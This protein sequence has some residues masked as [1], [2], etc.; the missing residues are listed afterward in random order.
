M[1][2][3]EDETYH[4]FGPYTREKGQVLFS[5]NGNDKWESKVFVQ[6]SGLGDNVYENYKYAWI[7]EE[8]ILNIGDSAVEI[9]CTE[10]DVDRVANNSGAEDGRYY[11]VIIE[12]FTNQI[13]AK[14]NIFNL[15]TDILAPTV[16]VEYST[17]EITNQNVTVNLTASEEIQGVEG[18]KLSEDRFQLTKEYSENTEEIIIIKDLVG[19]ETE[20]KI[21]IVNIDKVGPVANVEYSATE[22]TNQNVIVTINSDKEIQEVEGWEI[23]EDKKQLT[24]EYEQNVNEIV[25]LKDLIGNTTEQL[26]N[27]SNI[28]KVP[29]VIDVTYSNTELTNSNVIATITSNKKLEKLEGWELSEDKLHLTKEYTRNTKEEGEKV[30]VKDLVG[31]EF[32]QIITISNIDKAAPVPKII[33]STGKKTNQN[34]TV[35]I[36]VDEQIQP[37]EGWELSEDKLRLTK[38]YEANQEEVVILKDIL[39]NETEHLINISNIDKSPASLEVNYSSDDE[40]NQ[41]INVTIVSNEEIQSLEGW[42]LSQDRM[43]LSRNYI[44]SVEET[45]IVKDMAGNEIEQKIE[46]ICTKPEPLI[47][48]GDVNGDWQV[49]LSD[50]VIINKARLGELQLTEKEFLAADITGD[51]VI[52]IKDL[53]EMNKL[54][55]NK[56]EQ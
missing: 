41:S 44:E 48:K 40:T 54:R 42:E 43:Q 1:V 23:S 2:T 17:T 6:V 53:T 16:E 39:G 33:Y 22:I 50:M 36:V 11:L 21:Q 37:L 55:L 18:W 19:N 28:D 49:E 35:I 15:T 29:T 47:L 4:R 34:V 7:E 10:F 20:Q 26:I 27:V 32:E 14:S 30:L 8:T 51:G 56:S 31:N 24:K 13:I 5:S 46:V 45:I 52:D 38:I 3:I 12:K 25:I 9:E